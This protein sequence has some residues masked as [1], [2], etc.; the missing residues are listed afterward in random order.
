[1]SRKKIQKSVLGFV[2][3]LIVALVI[4]LGILLSG[5]IFGPKFQPG[6]TLPNVSLTCCDSGDG[7]AC[8]PLEGTGQKL[9][10]GGNEYGLLRSS[11]K[12]AEGVF[13]LKDSGEKFDSK[14]IILNTS[15]GYNPIHH[16]GVCDGEAIVGPGGKCV[17]IDNDLIV[18]TCR[19]GCNPTIPSDP[20]QVMHCGNNGVT[21]YGSDQSLYDVY[22]RLTGEDIPDIIKNCDKGAGG[23]ISVGQPTVVAPSVDPHVNL[24]LSTLEFIAQASIPW[25]SP[26]CKPAVYLYP[27]KT[28]L[29]SVKVN[30]SQSLT[31]TD[32]LYPVGGWNVMA[33][34][35]GII[36]YQGK[37]YDY[38]YYET[39]VADDMLTK[40]DQGYVVERSN[41]KSLFAKILP[42]LGLNIK[43]AKQFSDY[44]IATL[45][46]SKY[47]FVGI[48]PESSLYKYSQLDILPRPA[49]QIRVSLYFEALNE[50]KEVVEPEII[51]PVRSGFTVVEWGGIF[52]KHKGEKF[53]CFM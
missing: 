5:S 10:Y 8:K 48:V 25:M 23:N 22:F 18:Y 35:S 28:S 47:Y 7:D 17:R 4:I 45:P 30:S 14:P 29:V 16:A 42:K 12:F 26:W 52:K 21:C 51:T 11:V 33:N 2:N 6:G 15:D 41:L 20:R 31:Y 13:H 24:Q 38:L 34:P 39:K 40:P 19:E 53:S 43:E 27:E 50:K 44:W 1:M 37:P 46:D 9:T 36:S 49:S 32:P 3:I